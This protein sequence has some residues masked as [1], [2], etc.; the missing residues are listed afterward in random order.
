MKMAEDNTEICYELSTSF[1]TI[2][3]KDVASTLILS[4]QYN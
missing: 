2:V 3:V 1:N 4:T